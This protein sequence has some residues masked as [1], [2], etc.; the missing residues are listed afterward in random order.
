MVLITWLG[1]QLVM[2]GGGGGDDIT[3]NIQPFIFSY[4]RMCIII[5]LIMCLLH[6]HVYM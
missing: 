6:V 3:V 5:E 1:R 2:G 4:I